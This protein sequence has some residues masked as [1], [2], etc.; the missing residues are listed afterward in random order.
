MFPTDISTL[1][2]LPNDIE[3]IREFSLRRKKLKLLISGNG[4]R[5]SKMLIYIDNKIELERNN[6]SK[7][8]ANFAYTE[9]IKTLVKQ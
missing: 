7:D 2:P 4:D 1:F 9:V 6:I 5:V 3:I 8:V